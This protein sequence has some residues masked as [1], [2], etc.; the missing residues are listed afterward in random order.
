MQD[1]L[2]CSVISIVPFEIDEYKPGLY[3]GHFEIPASENNFPQ[4]LHVGE[5]VHY[6]EVDVARSI[7]VVNSPHVI[8]ES[9]VEDYLSAQLAIKSGETDVGPGIF[10]KL[11]KYDISKIIKECQPELENAKLRQYNWFV[12]L[13][14]MADDD[15]EKTR[16]HRAITDMQRK[17]AKILGL[18]KPWIVV[19]KAATQ[20][21]VSQDCPACG[22]QIKQGVILCPNCRCIIDYDRYKETKFATT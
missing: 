17:A 5:S 12:R 20:A 13:V 10:W 14:E 22:S 9:I 16:Q 15:W 18:E 21:I 19:P 3:P 2:I 1:E 6:V 4:I 11:G 8:A 7:R